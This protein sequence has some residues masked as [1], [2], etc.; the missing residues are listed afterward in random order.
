MTEP[1]YASIIAVNDDEQQPVAFNPG[2][3]LRLTDTDGKER[4]VRIVEI[5][6]RSAL[7]AYRPYA[8][9]GDRA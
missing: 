1:L 3:G 8:F 9:G 2:E 6:G 7:V 4:W 5:A